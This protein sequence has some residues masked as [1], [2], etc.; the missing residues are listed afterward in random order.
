MRAYIARSVPLIYILLLSIYGQYDIQQ[1][2]KPRSDT[3]VSFSYQTQETRTNLN[4]RVI[5][6]SYI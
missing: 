6:Y 1:K 3:N 4:A 2:K 5:E